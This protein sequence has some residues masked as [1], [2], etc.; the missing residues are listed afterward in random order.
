MKAIAAVAVLGLALAAGGC[1]YRPL[2]AKPE[3]GA[4]VSAELSRVSVS[5]QKSRAGQMVRNE[6]MAGFDAAPDGAYVLKMVP[7]E[8]TQDVSSLAFE[9]TERHRYR[10]SVAYELV[11]SRNG[12]ILTKGTS[13]SNVSFDTVKEPVADLRAAEN[14]RE[15]AAREV[16]QDLRLRLA[17]YMSSRNS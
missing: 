11:D 15:R 8:K 14:A 10:L 12:E 17:S 4:G 3:D 16:A 1:S 6:L 5:E 13:F 7:A 2:Y 9:K